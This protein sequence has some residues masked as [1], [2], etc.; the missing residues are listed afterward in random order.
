M[1]GR[2]RKKAAALLLSVIFVTGCVPFQPVADLF[3]E[4]TVT[5][6]ALMSDSELKRNLHAVGITGE[7][8]ESSPFCITTPSQIT[9]LSGI[10][11]YA[12]PC[13]GYYFILTEDIDMAGQDDFYPIGSHSNDGSYNDRRYEFYGYFDGQGHTAAAQNGRTEI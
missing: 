7:G 11:N 8:S 10:V 6:N 12:T 2:F 4:M 13:V 1:K 9:Y 5:A 3:D